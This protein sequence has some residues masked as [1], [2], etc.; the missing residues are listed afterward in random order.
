MDGTAYFARTALH[1]KKGESR[2][3]LLKELSIVDLQV[4][5]AC[6]VKEEKN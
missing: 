4:K 1:Q 5:T 6:F 2:K 3:L